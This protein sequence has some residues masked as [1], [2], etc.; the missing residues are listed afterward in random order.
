VDPDLDLDPEHC[1]FLLHKKLLLQKRYTEGTKDN[2]LIKNKNRCDRKPIIKV[3][4]FQRFWWEEGRGW[5]RGSPSMG[6][7]SKTGT[8]EIILYTYF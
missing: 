2:T 3:V 1:F 8:F 5:G 6:H 7:N 4:I